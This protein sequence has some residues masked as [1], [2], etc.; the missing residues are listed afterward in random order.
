MAGRHSRDGKRI[1]WLQFGGAA[2]ES[3]SPNG[4]ADQHWDVRRGRRGLRWRQQG[5]DKRQRGQQQESACHA[6]EEKTEEQSPAIE[7]HLCFISQSSLLNARRDLGSRRRRD[8]GVLGLH[9]KEFGLDEPHLRVIQLR[10]GD[11]AVLV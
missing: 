4:F 3:A 9:Q 11:H 1:D 8:A 5:A 10:R 2:A 6:R 7:P